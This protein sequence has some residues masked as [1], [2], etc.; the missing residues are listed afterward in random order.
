MTDTIDPAEAETAELATA[1][2]DALPADGTHY[3]VPAGRYHRWPAASNSFLGQLDRSPAHAR[4]WVDHPAAATPDMAFGTA[5][6]A[7]VLEPDLFAATY[8][9]AGRC[10]ANTAGA[11]RCGNSARPTTDGRQLC[12]V[13][14]K[15]AT[16]ADAG[17]V[18]TADDAAVLAAMRA[19]VGRHPVAGPLLAL[20]GPTEVSIVWADEATGVRCKARVDRVASNDVATVAVDLKTTRD[21]SP[22]GFGRAA[23]DRGYRRQAAFYLRGLAAVG[24][25]ADA[26][27][28]VAVEK[29]APHAV[30]VYQLRPADLADEQADVDRLLARFAECVRSGVWPGYADDAAV[31]LELPDWVARR[32]EREAEGPPF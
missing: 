6:H 32:R 20:G 11:K 30:A 15:A 2:D 21:A 18:L 31:A 22:A 25:P 14:G 1:H 10:E 8:T 24:F 17:R 4:H 9:V 28:F 16:F 3:D 19:A 7:A 26:F 13:H 5:V 27:A 29:D 12:G 23:L